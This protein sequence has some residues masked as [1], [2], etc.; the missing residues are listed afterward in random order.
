MPFDQSVMKDML[1]T[2]SGLREGVEFGSLA[3]PA[4][5]PA[6]APSPEA[7]CPGEPALASPR[8]PDQDRWRLSEADLA[9]SPCLCR[10]QCIED[11][12]VLVSTYLRSFTQAPCT[13]H[14]NICK[15]ML[16][17]SLSASCS[18]CRTATE[19]CRRCF[20][21]MAT[22]HGLLI[23]HTFVHVVWTGCLRQK[24][25]LP[26]KGSCLRTLALHPFQ[27]F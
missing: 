4:H 18:V 20:Q 12:S 24:A 26:R 8:R 19:A 10:A 27:A 13:S 21:K 17:V 5:T 11:V 9:V 15:S 22:L 2:S 23:E 7:Q 3:Q 16:A 25:W 6:G 14:L 1:L